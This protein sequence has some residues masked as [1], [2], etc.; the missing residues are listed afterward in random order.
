MGVLI[1]PADEPWR[2]A[3]GAS[4]RVNGPVEEDDLKQFC[5]IA[6]ESD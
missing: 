3:G 4:K 2:M 5:F 6:E 1:E